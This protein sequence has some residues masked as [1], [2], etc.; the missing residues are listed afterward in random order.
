[1][2]RDWFSIG[3]FVFAVVFF[4]AG[5]VFIRWPDFQHK[6]EVSRVLNRP[7]VLDLRLTMQFDKPPIYQEQYTFRNDNGISTAL[8]RVQGY[9]GKVV[10]IELPPD[11][12]FAVTFLFQKVVMDGIW[13]LTNKPPIG[14]TS[15]HYTLYIHQVADGKQGSRTITFTDPSYWAVTAGRQYEMHL[16]KSGP[17]PDLL[18]LKSTSEA[19]PRFVAIVRDIRTFGPPTFRSKVV[20]ATAMVR[21]SR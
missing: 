16:S 1:M 17:I 21:A 4:V 3:I 7:S 18:K 13:K 11:K 5:L 19:D 2:R 9:S 8:Y 14:N 10:T 6:A 20:Q 12:T 15:V